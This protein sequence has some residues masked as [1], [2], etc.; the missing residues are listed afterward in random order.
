M[1]RCHT[2]I[3]TICYYD[4]DNFKEKVLS[5]FSCHCQPLGHLSLLH[6]KQNST[7][8]REKATTWSMSN[9]CFWFHLI[10]T[11]LSSHVGVIIRRELRTM[12]WSSFKKRINVKNVYNVPSTKNLPFLKASTYLQYSNGLEVSEFRTRIFFFKFDQYL[13][14]LMPCLESWIVL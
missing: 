12:I 3:V 13:A 6:R 2:V 8:L 5:G 11:W 4:N 7:Q 9:N 14:F 1:T 10:R